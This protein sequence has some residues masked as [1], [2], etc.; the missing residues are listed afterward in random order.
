MNGVRPAELYCQKRTLTALKAIADTQEL[1]PD[2]IADLWLTERLEK[3]YPNLMKVLEINEAEYAVFSKTQK[4][5]LA[6]AV[7]QP[8]IT[9]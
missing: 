6:D 4:K 1:T 9:P 7:N 8:G 5:L 3:E 2:A